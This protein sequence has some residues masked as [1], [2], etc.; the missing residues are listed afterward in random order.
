MSPKQVFADAVA[1]QNELWRIIRV[2]EREHSVPPSG[3]EM[4]SPV[5]TGN[6][7]NSEGTRPGVDQ[8][9]SDEEPDEKFNELETPSAHDRVWEILES[10]SSS[11]SSLQFRK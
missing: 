10:L 1:S 3:E 6:A 9:N 2:L 5:E 8:D 4:K 11:S 7:R